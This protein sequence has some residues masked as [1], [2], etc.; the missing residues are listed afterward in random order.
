MQKAIDEMAAGLESEERYI[1]ADLRFHLLIA[2]A[3]GNRIASHLMNAIRGQLQ[4]GLGTAY[5]IKGSPEASLEQH[6]DI[7]DAIEARRPDEARA[8]MHVHI[9]RVEHE[10]HAAK[11]RKR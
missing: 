9:S 6:R 11:K 2:E 7:L 4:R 10:I 5:H 1:G 3:S 8:A